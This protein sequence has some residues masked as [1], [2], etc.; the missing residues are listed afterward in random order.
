MTIQQRAREGKKDPLFRIEEEVFSVV[1]EKLNV[2][3][4]LVESGSIRVTKLVHER[5]EIVDEALME[6]QIHVKRVPINRYI[7]AAIGTRYEGKTMIIP[8]I[9]EVL[10]KR[11]LL[12][13]ELHIT[14][15]Q[16][17][18]HSPQSVTLRH[19]EVIVEHIA[20]PSDV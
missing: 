16:K 1:E 8:V 5:E 3:K 19:E 6:E 9:E 12:K 7:D 11:L 15:E 13:E 4:K 20:P 14:K 18:R 10:V 17:E 2:E